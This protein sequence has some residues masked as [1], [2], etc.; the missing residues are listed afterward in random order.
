[1][2]LDILRTEIDW[3]RKTTTTT[4]GPDGTG[5]ERI[6]WKAGGVRGSCH[7]FQTQP[8]PWLLRAAVLLLLC[9]AL[10]LLGDFKKLSLQSKHGFEC[11]VGRRGE[12][13]GRAGRRMRPQIGQRLPRTGQSRCPRPSGPAPALCF[14][15][16]PAAG[17]PWLRWAHIVSLLLLSQK[18]LLLQRGAGNV[19]AHKQRHGG[20]AKAPG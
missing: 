10:F 16:R 3:K 17:S 11:L 18:R 5:Q 9:S 7:P 14:R 1:M 20:P 15:V 13:L 2:L 8:W 4:H 6:V 12:R 19:F